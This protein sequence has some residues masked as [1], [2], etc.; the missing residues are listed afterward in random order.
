MGQV[1]YHDVV[2]AFFAL[3]II[4]AAMVVIANIVAMIH[5]FVSGDDE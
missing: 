5:D 4:V 3:V 1:T 2:G